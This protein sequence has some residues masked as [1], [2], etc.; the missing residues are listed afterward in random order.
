[1]F[2][3]KIDSCFPNESYQNGMIDEAILCCGFKTC[4]RNQALQ[5]CSEKE[6]KREQGGERV[7]RGRR[8]GGVE[9]G[10]PRACG[11]RVG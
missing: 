6:Q 3:S 7:A 10:I 8:S 11:R 2:E 9:I 4:V 1:M 5:Q